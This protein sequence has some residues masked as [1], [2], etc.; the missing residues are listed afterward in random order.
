[1]DVLSWQIGVPL[2]GFVGSLDR[3]TT[4]FSL[5]E[6]DVAFLLSNILSKVSPASVVIC[7]SFSA[8]PYEEFAILDCDY[9]FLTN[10]SIYQT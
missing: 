10:L 4:A 8:D 1:L 5:A 6:C 2:A 7:T 3:S 9:Y